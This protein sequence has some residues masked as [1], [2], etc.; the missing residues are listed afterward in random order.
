MAVAQ[1]VEIAVACKAMLLHGV[2]LCIDMQL[3]I[4]G[5]PHNR[6]QYGCTT[7]PKALVTVP[8]VFSATFCQACH[9]GSMFGYLDGNDIVS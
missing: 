6:E 7:V 3:V 1:V 4:I 8:Q 9:F 5:L 2:G